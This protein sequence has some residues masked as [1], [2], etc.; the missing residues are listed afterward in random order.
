MK[1]GLKVLLPLIDSHMVS[2]GQ[3][4]FIVDKV[5]SGHILMTDEYQVEFSQPETWAAVGIFGKVLALPVEVLKNAD[6]SSFG[7]SGSAGSEGGEVDSASATNGG[8]Y[9][10]SVVGAGSGITGEHYS[11][12]DA[13]AELRREADYNDLSGRN[14]SVME[15]VAAKLEASAA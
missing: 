13:I 15:I 2:E 12:E 8:G 14:A 7:G 5:D 1:K 9:G 4:G 6:G 10:S 11:V 3:E